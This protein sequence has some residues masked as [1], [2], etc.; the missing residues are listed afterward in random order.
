MHLSYVKFSFGMT[1]F[2]TLHCLSWLEVLHK[3]YDSHPFL[4]Y[5]LL[6]YKLFILLM[7]KVDYNF[8]LSVIKK[9]NLWSLV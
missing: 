2:K 5:H 9:W 8:F 3:I 7:I 4:D 1:F 6:I